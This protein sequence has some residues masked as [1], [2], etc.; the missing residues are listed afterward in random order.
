MLA[1]VAVG[2]KSL[3]G[4]S[5][6]RLTRDSSVEAGTRCQSAWGDRSR[7][8]LRER[9]IKEACLARYGIEESGTSST[10]LRS[11]TELELGGQPSATQQHS[12]RSTL[13]GLWSRL[14]A[15]VRLT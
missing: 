12:P 5:G 13:P 9:I 6:R 8:G 4:Q 2:G 11:A 3:P 14:S 7:G 15:T 1:T 10:E